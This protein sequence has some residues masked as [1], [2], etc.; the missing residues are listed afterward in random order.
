LSPR[1][2]FGFS[3]NG[4]FAAFVA[5]TQK[6]AHDGRGPINTSAVTFSYS[7]GGAARKFITVE[8][9]GVPK[10]LAPL[11]KAGLEVLDRGIP[12]RLLDG[13]K[14]LWNVGNVPD[15][16]QLLG[17]PNPTDPNSYATEDQMLANVF[18]FNVMG[19]DASD[20]QF[21]LD[22]DDLKLKLKTRPKDQPTFQKTEEL[23]RA[24]AAAMGGK[25]V[26]FPLWDG[27]AHNKVISTHPLGGCRM[28]ND[29][30]EGVVNGK[31]QLFYA[32]NPDK[33]AVYPGLYV[34]DGSMVPNALA[35]NPTLTITALTLKMMAQVQ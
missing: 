17:G 16:M 28:A 1:L 15:L 6:A 20:G 26:A 25:Y 23:L 22:G 30:D 8:D 21:S 9:A 31:G 35:V 10:M 32:G 12:G 18:F 13:L 33:K 34:V 5:N 29:R 4:D 19:V 2:G 27:F 14:G 11:V 24:F 3:T 7:D